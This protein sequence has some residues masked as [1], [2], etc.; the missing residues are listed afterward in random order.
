MKP[1]VLVPTDEQQAI[2]TATRQPESLM[3][4]AY[5]GCS[6]TT[7]LAM[8]APK[9]Q[10]A[11]LALAFN[12][13]IAE[14]LRP[15]LGGHFEVKTINGLGHQAWARGLGSSITRVEIDDRKLGKLVSR[16]GKDRKVD[17]ASESWDQIR[18]LVTAAMQAGISPGDQG[19]P[20]RPDTPGEWQELADGLWIDRED[21][22]LVYDLARETLVESIALA[23]AG[24]ISFDDQVYCPTVL[25]GIWP[26]FPVVAVDEAQDLSPLN[27]RMIELALRPGGRLIAVGDPKQA[28]YAW[29]GADGQSMR[30]MRVLAGTWL[31]LPLATTFRCPKV[32]V[33]RQ[34]EHAPGFRAWEGNVQGRVVWAPRVGDEPVSAGGWSWEW[35][36]GLAPPGATIAIL[37]RNNAPLVKLAFRLIRQS[38]PV[39]MAGRDIGKGLEALVAKLVRDE[40][41]PISTLLGRLVEW[42]GNEQAKALV[43]GREDQ[44][45]AISD[46]AECIRAVV[47]GAEPKTVGGLK[48]VIKQ[49]FTREAGRVVLSSIHRAKGL[50]WDLVVHLDPWRVPSKQAHEAA[51]RGDLRPLEQERNLRYVAETRTKQVLVEANLEDFR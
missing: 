20:L 6:K 44:L 17:L 36:Q 47:D 37:C 5:A 26:K 16:V 13:K 49:L 40:E 4:T 24:V 33:A 25:G 34:Q 50:E 39:V 18:R 1:P 42:E 2:I 46:R 51:K 23:R 38:V 9:V 10:S 30:T 27:H 48:A 43:Q 14:E 28:I 31:D 15:R 45:A 29:R 8:L 32:V 41:A 21:F 12:R 11:A 3:I 35:L 19:Q 7:T 22:P